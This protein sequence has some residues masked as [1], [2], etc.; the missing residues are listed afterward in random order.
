MPSPKWKLIVDIGY[1]QVSTTADTMSEVDTKVQNLLS[2][3][4]L[5]TP[6]DKT[7]PMA[8]FL[9]GFTSLRLLLQK[10]SRSSRDDQLVNLALTSYDAYQRSGQNDKDLACMVARDFMLLSK[11]TV[12]SEKVAWSGNRAVTMDYMSVPNGIYGANPKTSTGT[13]AQG[14]TA[15]NSQ[16][17]LSQQFMID[18]T[19]DERT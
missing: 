2:L 10:K 1:S 7:S 13:L 19:K 5:H 15:G 18:K 6:E 8:S 4:Q 16:G 9:P 12:L 17:S 3:V 14:P 11:Q